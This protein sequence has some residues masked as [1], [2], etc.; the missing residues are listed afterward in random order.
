MSIVAGLRSSLSRRGCDRTTK[1]FER[2]LVDALALT[3]PTLLCALEAPVTSDFNR[4]QLTFGWQAA[5][6]HGL[7]SL[8]GG[9]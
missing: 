4:S 5:I 9:R 7:F 6:L 3:D 1:V 8:C 2:R